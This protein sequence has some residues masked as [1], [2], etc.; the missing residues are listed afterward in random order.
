MLE[1]SRLVTYT[2]KLNSRQRLYTLNADYL[3]TRFSTLVQ[4]MEKEKSII[5]GL[6]AAM[7]KNK[8]DNPALNKVF[9]LYIQSL[10][11][12]VLLLQQTT[13]ALKAVK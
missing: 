3:L 4:N 5:K 10:D 6:M 9:V 2:F 1:K 8:S 11:N 7:K 12:N 13:K